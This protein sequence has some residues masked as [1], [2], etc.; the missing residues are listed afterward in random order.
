[1]CPT[2]Y[3][4]EAH[5]AAILK[6]DPLCYDKNMATKAMVEGNNSFDDRTYVR[7]QI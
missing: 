7:F 2:L 3:D 6:E 1:L 4:T 5:L